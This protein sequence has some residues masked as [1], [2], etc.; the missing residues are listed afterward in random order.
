MG[1]E[2]FDDAAL[3]FKYQ[4]QREVQITSGSEMDRGGKIFKAA[5]KSANSSRSSVGLISSSPKSVGSSDRVA[6]SPVK[7]DLCLCGKRKDDAP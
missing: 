3:G 6:C 1:D 2:C 4:E 5:E 7:L